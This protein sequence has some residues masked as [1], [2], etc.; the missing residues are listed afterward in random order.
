MPKNQGCKTPLWR[1][2]GKLDNNHSNQIQLIPA[3]STLAIDGNGL[4]H[5]L[6]AV[7]YSR[8]FDQVTGGGAATADCS[9][10]QDL[11][12]QSVTACLPQSMPLSMLN[13][14]TREFVDSLQKNSLTLH[15][16]WDGSG[17]RM[18]AATAKKRR[19]VRDD[20]WS[21][22]YQYCHIGVL[23]FRS[24]CLNNFAKSFPISRLFMAQVYS[25]LSSYPDVEHVHCDEEADR[26][27]ATA[28]AFSEGVFSVGM[29]TDYCLFPNTKYVPLSS[30]DAS[31]SHVTGSVITRDG[32]ADLFHL[33]S[34]ESM[35]ELGILMG[36][37]YIGHAKEAYLDYLAPTAEDAIEHLQQR[38]NNY[39]VSSSSDE[40]QLAIDFTRALYGFHPLDD[41]PMDSSDVEDSDS[42]DEDDD[43][44]TGDRPSLPFGLDLSLTTLEKL[45]FSLMATVTRAIQ[46]YVDQST[47]TSPMITQE[48]LDT[49]QELSQALEL[50]LD[51]R[52]G[53]S[54]RP[55]WEDIRAAY[56]IEKTISY[57]LR[58]NAGSPAARY[59][60]PMKLF[61]YLSFAN[62]MNAKQIKE[63]VEAPPAPEGVKDTSATVAR[64]RLPIDEFEEDILRSISTQRVT[65]IHGETGCGKSSRVPVMIMRNALPDNK[66]RDVKMF[67]SQPRRIAAKSL[68]E[69]VRSTEPDIRHK[70]ALRMGHG[71]R[72][73]ESKETRAWFVTTGYLVRLLA[74]MPE[75]FNDVSHLIIDE[76]KTK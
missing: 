14:V 56:L 5:F 26:Q 32:L 23:P 2:D 43:D 1:D 30:L 58:V 63:I 6:H 52:T 9:C 40:V 36:N 18:K 7:A 67:I 37:D 39:H 25:T 50:K 61:D 65:I 29:D 28:S 73:Y 42:E 3:Y 75:R 66:L 31:G 62:M 64:P 4:A 24:P 57:A 53:M 34:S 12:P 22:L 10:K 44:A 60:S 38:A 55:T 13:Q 19:G 8:Y 49:F 54:Q 72:E 21:N 11:S 20:E 70:M 47:E 27:V 45:D 16:Y 69:R 33:P 15:I 48:Q 41:F 71:E 74:N 46:G 51:K 59:T 35:V 68:V 76:G 17:R